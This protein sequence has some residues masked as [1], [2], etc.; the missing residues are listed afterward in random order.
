MSDEELS[1]YYSSLES[2]HWEYPTLNPPERQ[3]SA[4]IASLPQGSNI[5]DFGCSSGRLLKP[6]VNQHR[7]FGFEINGAA[8]EKAAERGLVM[9]TEET[10]WSEHENQFHM[11]I[12]VDVFEH[13][14][15]PAELLRRLWSLISPGGCL[16][17]GT[18]NGDHW[19]CRLDPAQFWYFRNLEHLCML[20]HKYAVYLEKELAGAGKSWVTLS[21]YD[22]PWH[23]RMRLHVA[24]AA[25]WIV[26]YSPEPVRMVLS[27][28]P[29]FRKAARWNNAPNY[30]CCKDHVVFTV[31]KPSVEVS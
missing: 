6:W 10:L 16:V 15:H 7:C 30:G 22:V 24:H 20:T 25:Y 8:A 13:L 21:H 4:L 1:A 26:Q 29:G 2:G 12:L 17:V 3:I 23:A 5:L 27:W 18:G 28:L 9:L 31:K 19:A 11:V 14:R